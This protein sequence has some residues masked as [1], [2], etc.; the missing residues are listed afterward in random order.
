MKPNSAQK[1]ILVVGFVLLLCLALFPPWREAAEKEVDF[2]KDIGRGFVLSPPQPV[3]VDCYF[4]GCKTAPSS[5]FH[6]L[7]YRKL[8]LSQLITVGIV[9][10]A[11]LWIF[12]L[13]R[14]GTGA[15]L[16]VRKT[17]LQFCVLIA[18]LIPLDGRYPFGAWLADIP[19]QIVLHELLL[20]PIIFMVLI[21]LGCVCM[22]FLLLSAVIKTNAALSRRRM[23]ARP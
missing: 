5:Y 9:G 20:I 22:I 13:N 6:V 3:A 17:R 11:L 19:R 12:R 10:L 8:L 2:R 1:V 7:I 4:V 23:V 15:S 16:G 18:L 21:Y 14:D